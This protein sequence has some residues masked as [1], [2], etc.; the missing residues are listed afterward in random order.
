MPWSISWIPALPQMS[1]S[2]HWA[3]AVPFCPVPA[4]NPADPM[5]CHELPH[6]VPFPAWAVATVPSL[7][8]GSAYAGDLNVQ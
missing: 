7:P 8:G 4:S 2:C 1:Q 3:A 6:G 5:Y